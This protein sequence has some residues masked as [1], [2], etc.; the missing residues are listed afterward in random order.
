MSHGP[1]FAGQVTTPNGDPIMAAKFLV[2]A[3]R[4]RMV[5]RERLLD[6]VSRGVD[7]PLT[8]ISG[9]A[10]AG[11][12]ALLSSW[13]AAGR[14][15][16][17]V[18]WVCLDEE[19]AQPGVFWSYLWA[20]LVREGLRLPNASAPPVR[21]DA[22]EH[23]LL[24]RLAADLCERAEPIVVILDNAEVLAGS[25]VPSQVNY[26]LSH[27]GP[28]LRLVIAGRAGLA[29]PVHRYRLAATVTEIGFRDLAFVGPEVDALLSAHGIDLP[30]EAVTASEGMTHGWAAGLVLAA[31]LCRGTGDAGEVGVPARGGDFRAISDYFITEVLS[32]Q[33]PGVQ[34]LLVRMSIV[35][36]LWPDLA[37]AL[38]GRTDVPGLLAELARSDALLVTGGVEHA[39]Y[40][41]PPLVRNLLQRQLRDKDPD[42][43]TQL[44]QLA[45]RWL[46]ARGSLTEAVGHALAGGDW[47]HAVTLLVEA[48]G[49]GRLLLGSSADSL[50]ARFA[51]LPVDV[52]GPEAAVV[53]AAVALAAQDTELCCKHLA[54]ARELVFDG[55]DRDTQALELAI[56]AAE[57]MCTYARGDID[58]TLSATT[59][60]QVI[61]TD[62]HA[63][64][65]STAVQQLRALLLVTSGSTLIR[66]GEMERA[67]GVLAEGLRDA[68]EADWDDLRVRCLGELALVAVLRGERHRAA[69]FARKAEAIADVR[70]VPVE[71]RPPAVAVAL[72]WGHADAYELAAARRYADLASRSRA[73]CGDPVPTGLLALVRA[74]LRRSAGDLD[75]A[76]IALEQV[77]SCPPGTP[78]PRWLEGLLLAESAAVRLVGGAPDVDEDGLR[79]AAPRCARC[80]LAL[81]SL[82]LAGGDFE[83]AVERAGDILRRTDLSADLRVE[84]EL[85]V[86]E[87]ELARHRQEPARTAL[88]RALA[89]AATQTLRRPFTE[90]SLRLRAFL[91]RERDLFRQ[92]EWLTG[93]EAAAPVPRTLAGVGAGGTGVLV[94]P[95]TEREAEVL[96]HLAMLLSTDEIARK[97]FISV[98]T[99]KTHIRGIFRKLSVSRRN[100]AIRRAR[101]LGLV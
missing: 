20:G 26:L 6:L 5:V 1:Q 100:D 66:A 46:A 94:E 4:P 41:Q 8:L 68:E 30:R 47:R 63:R 84:A 99:V 64:A 61:L 72:A 23:T 44:H 55:A 53:R 21:P 32:S 77:S 83:D 80:R 54:G 67:A 38:T 51:D 27:A 81:A 75:G 88:E 76:L 92:H 96:Q 3:L 95:L 87:G 50:V 16:G 18:L 39:W 19:D 42:S 12:T 45:A 24:V 10:G 73:I 79:E 49:M 25:V 90:A 40:E 57:A 29:L 70:R 37:F 101:D 15:P 11:K 74:R 59:A 31:P 82:M 60:A 13:V 33:P 98:N 91:R 22:V 58:G 36:Q 34:D 97:M 52:T 9:P 35:R 85:L 56:S 78:L 93:G 17:Q 86:C 43:V 69:R 89:L 7:G 65:D 71:E 14:S 48:R 62:A 2:P 28:Q